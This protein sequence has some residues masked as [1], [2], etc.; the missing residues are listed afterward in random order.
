MRVNAATERTWTANGHE[1]IE[2]SLLRN[3]DTGGRTSLVRMREGARFP[4]HRHLGHEEILVIE[5]RVPDC[6]CH[7]GKW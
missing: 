7:P 6:R 2:R 5:G 4:R 1:G 3:N